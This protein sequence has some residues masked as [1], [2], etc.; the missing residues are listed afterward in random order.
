MRILAVIVWSAVMILL[1]GLA[2]MHAGAGRQPAVL[3]ACAAPPPG[4]V[5]PVYPPGCTPPPSP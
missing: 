4:D 5:N 2:I 1:A 3:P